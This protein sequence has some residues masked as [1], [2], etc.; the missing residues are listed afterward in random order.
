VNID[1]G[2]VCRNKTDCP[3]GKDCI[4]GKCVD[5][6]EDIGFDAGMD[7]MEIGDGGKYCTKDD[8]CP[9]NYKCNLSSNTCEE[10]K[11]PKVCLSEKEM[12]FGYVQYG[13][14]KEKCVVLT[15]CGDATLN[16][17]GV[18]FGE[19]TSSAYKFKAGQEYTK[20]LSPNSSE[21]LDICVIVTPN[22]EEAP[23]GTVEVYN[24]SAIPKFVI[25]LR[26]QYKGS[27]D[28]VFVDENNKSFWP[29]GSTSTFKVDF[30]LVGPGNRKSLK[31]RITNATDG[32]KPLL[33]KSLDRFATQ[34]NGRFFDISDDTKEL[35]PPIVVGPSQIIGLELIYA[36]TQRSP[37]D[38]GNLLIETNDFDIDNNGTADNGKLLVE[39]S[40]V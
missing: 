6:E 39:C 40:G 25:P 15:N 29:D 38:S 2:F 27:A 20:K 3:S 5:V 17:S 34:F 33:I 22:S 35:T 23:Q 24:D 19:N 9:E 14:S 18:A 12:D 8:E 26:S 7:I 10:V 1:T 4:S 28:L 36:P 13:Q 11:M 32:D 37:K 16:I 21:Y 30:G 31:F